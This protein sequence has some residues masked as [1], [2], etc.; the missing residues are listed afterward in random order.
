MDQAL[1]P[2]E[3]NGIGRHFSLKAARFQAM[4]IPKC[5]RAPGNEDVRWFGLR[6]SRFWTAE[7]IIRLGSQA[8]SGR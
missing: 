5:K 2:W 1:V 6:S 4:A 8:G 3:K 7:R